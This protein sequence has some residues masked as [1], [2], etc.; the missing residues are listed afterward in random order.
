MSQSIEN[1]GF[2]SN[3]TEFEETTPSSL[4]LPP[5]QVPLQGSTIPPTDPLTSATAAAAPAP[6]PADQ[7]SPVLTHIASI[8][9]QAEETLRT[10]THD[11]DMSTLSF[12]AHISLGKSPQSLLDLQLLN[13]QF[14][15]VATF[16]TSTTVLG[17][18]EGVDA[19]KLEA[20]CN[21]VCVLCVFGLVFKGRLVSL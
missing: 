12:I 17:Y 10:I 11:M 14:E 15:H 2:E 4:T 16:A 21:S 13:T 9:T 8:T 3:V 18:L 5:P 19:E 7:V 1:N 6:V 20:A